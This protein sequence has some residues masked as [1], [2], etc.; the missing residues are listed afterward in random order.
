MYSYLP[1]NFVLVGWLVGRPVRLLK[2]KF[3]VFMPYVYINIIKTK[4]VSKYIS[5][6]HRKV[7]VFK[8]TLTLFLQ[9]ICNYL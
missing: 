1:H 6:S 4:R 5:K 8:H 7:F 9:L 3:N 2:F